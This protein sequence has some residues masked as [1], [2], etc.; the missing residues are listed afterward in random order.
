ML[1]MKVLSNVQRHRS[2]RDG[3]SRLLGMQL[4]EC[5]PLPPLCGWSI[6]EARTAAATRRRPPAF[7]DLSNVTI[8]TDAV[9]L[10]A[11]RLASKSTFS[12]DELFAVGS[13]L[14]VGY[15]Q[16]AFN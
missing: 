6:A 11:R 3:I 5:N 2:F 10:V 4:Y 8:H 12:F 9:A 7:V 1:T 15:L 14:P 16:V 13:I